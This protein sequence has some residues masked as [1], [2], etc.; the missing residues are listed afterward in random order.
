MKTRR[1]LISTG[2]NS[3]PN[4]EHSLDRVMHALAPKFMTARSGVL[5]SGVYITMDSIGGAKA[6]R[7]IRHQWH[8]LEMVLDVK[9]LHAP[10][11]IC[12][13][14]PKLFAVLD[15]HPDIAHLRAICILL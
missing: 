11:H 8:S 4:T 14:E 13:I 15:I 2:T 3:R 12:K 7:V 6:S 9:V 5:S 10:V 1:Q